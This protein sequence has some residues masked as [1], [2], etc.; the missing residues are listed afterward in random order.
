MTK[1]TRRFRKSGRRSRISRRKGFGGRRKYMGKNI[2]GKGARR[3]AKNCKRSRKFISKRNRRLMR[4]GVVNT[5]TGNEGE[6][7]PLLNPGQGQVPDAA[8]NVSGQVLSPNTDS[9]SKVS[10]KIEIF[11]IGKDGSRSEWPKKITGS[12]QSDWS[13]FESKYDDNDND[14]LNRPA[15]TE[16][17][18]ILIRERATQLSDMFEDV[19]F[20]E[21]SK[22]IKSRDMDSVRDW[23]KNQERKYNTKIYRA[24]LMA[25]AKYSSRNVLDLKL[26]TV[27]LRDYLNGTKIDIDHVY[28]VAKLQKKKKVLGFHDVFLVLVLNENDN[29]WVIKIFQ[30]V[31]GQIGTTYTIAFPGGCYPFTEAGQKPM[32]NMTPTSITA[33]ATND[34]N[35]SSDVYLESDENSNL[36]FRR[37]E[38]PGL[39]FVFQEWR[40]PP[41]TIMAS[42]IG[43]TNWGEFKWS[44]GDGDEDKKIWVPFPYYYAQVFNK[45]TGANDTIKLTVQKDSLRGLKTVLPF[46]AYIIR[47]VIAKTGKLENTKE[48]VVWSI[49]PDLLT[50][51]VPTC[52]KPVE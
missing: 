30:E 22:V 6:A 12:I 8:S 25:S 49:N 50:K 29:T 14:R 33:K 21:I 27:P 52:S 31:G 41:P 35:E 39:P 45:I 51:D 18:E 19:D 3:G 28:M 15:P 40:E 32:N 2:S 13:K 46:V 7:E 47:R 43:N 20:D 24:E 48:P 10:E 11:A 5:V 23:L 9:P 37:I 4:G 34:K 26:Q 42:E 16:N 17:D 1:V 36:F 38:M 44:K